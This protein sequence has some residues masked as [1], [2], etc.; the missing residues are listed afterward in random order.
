MR[1]F[2]E[3][4]D[5]VV[6]KCWNVARCGLIICIIQI[7]HVETIRAHFSFYWVECWF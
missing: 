1:W 3:N 6:G 2:L 7:P 5:L 4:V